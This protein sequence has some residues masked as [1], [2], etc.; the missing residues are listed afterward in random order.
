MVQN[1]ITSPRGEKDD[2]WTGVELGLLPLTSKKFNITVP[3]P[4]SLPPE[5]D[6][7]QVPAASSV[8]GEHSAPGEVQVCIFFFLF[9]HVF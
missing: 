2:F 1:F 5:L 6:G 8:P 4:D 9:W 3:I 7:K